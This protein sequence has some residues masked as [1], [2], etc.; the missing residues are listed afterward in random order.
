MK[1]YIRCLFFVLLAAAAVIGCKS[2]S[3]PMATEQPPTEAAL[4]PAILERMKRMPGYDIKN[5]QFILSSRIVLNSILTRSN[6]SRTNNGVIFENIQEKSNITLPN[7]IVG[8]AINLQDSGDEILLRVYFEEKANE[9][10]F[11]PATHFLVFSAKK[12]DMHSYFLLKYDP[13]ADTQLLTE[14]KG[15]L[16]YGGDTYNV[17][18]NGGSP[19]LLLRFEQRTSV[20]DKNR[21]I[22][23]RAVSSR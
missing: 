21:I 23:G 5:Q 16:A 7:K 17:L 13:G 9:T 4:T 22:R 14:E 12:T 10:K 11:P 2:P 20:V 19:Y 18:F 8:E 15:T 1:S 3:A 6:D